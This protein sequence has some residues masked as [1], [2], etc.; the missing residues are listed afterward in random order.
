MIIVM[1]LQRLFLPSKYEL[2]KLHTNLIKGID[3]NSV[4]YTPVSGFP[5]TEVVYWSSSEIYP[6]A[7]NQIFS[8]GIFAGNDEQSFTNKTY[9]SMY[10][11]S[12]LFNNLTAIG[13]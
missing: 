3:E 7:C 2:S 8:T 11:V 6:Y 1:G 13:P 5:T 10:V 4:T 9:P 12:E